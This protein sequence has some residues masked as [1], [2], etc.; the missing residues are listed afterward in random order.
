MHVLNAA[1]NGGT[2]TFVFTSSIAVY[3]AGQTP[4]SENTV[5]QPEDPYGVA[6]YAVELDLRAAHEMFGIDFV[7]FR[8]H[9]VYGP[10][11]NVAD[12]YRNVIGIFMRQMLTG[13]PMTI[14]GDGSQ[15]RAFSY[16]D[17]VAPFIARAPLVDGA[18][19]QVFNVGT[20]RAYTLNELAAA[21]AAA[22]GAPGAEVRHLPARKEVQHAVAAHGKLACV[23]GPAPPPT[24]L[25][26]GLASMAAWATDLH[27]RGVFTPV[28]YEGV[29]VP[30]G[31]PPSWVPAPPAAGARICTAAARTEIARQYSRWATTSHDITEHIPL[32]RKLARNAV[33]TT[34]L[35]V[36]DGIA[37]W[38]FAAAVADRAAAGLPAIYRAVDVTKRA[39]IATLDAAM[40][41]CPDVDYAFLEGN[42]L[43]VAVW[44]S[45]FLLIDTWH[46][47][48][49]IIKELPRWA[50]HVTT[51]IAMHDTSLFG[52]QDEP[53]RDMPVNHALLAKTQKAGLWT[54]LQDF[55][56]TDAGSHWRVMERRHSSNGLTVLERVKPES[57]VRKKG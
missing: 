6:K 2:K 51:Y 54:G 17:D 1:V 8:P 48:K 9:N 14:F 47:Y 36:R 37:A 30:R 13:E 26:A 50:P 55:L 31:L 22:M 25:A 23:F 29:E 42:D 52:E 46:V 18:R 28:E 11:Q 20:D 39:S 10:G 57:S 33:R 21:V 19:N 43:E 32:L 16:I 15:T 45:D 38:A 53:D 27:A 24:T 5:P 35:G 7:V 49:Q 3:G 56:T 41:G 34:E 40:A 44:E 4:L 12:K